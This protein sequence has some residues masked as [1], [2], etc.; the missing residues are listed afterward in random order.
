MT[1][2]AIATALLASRPD[3]ITQPQKACR[4]ALLLADML[5]SEYYKQ[6]EEQQSEEE[7]VKKVF[8]S[9]RP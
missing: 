6:I 7:K 5:I 9:W 1:K 4:E 3:A 8:M 2:L